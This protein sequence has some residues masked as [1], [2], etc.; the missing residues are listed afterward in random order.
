MQALQPQG[1]YIRIFYINFIIAEEL[2]KIDTKTLFE[3]GGRIRE[4]FRQ[5]Y[6]TIVNVMRQIYINMVTN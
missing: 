5:N 1:I 3:K 6:F 4:S 2:I